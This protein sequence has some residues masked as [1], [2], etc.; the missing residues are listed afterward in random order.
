MA[1]NIDK[2]TNFCIEEIEKF[3]AEHRDETFYGFAIDAGGL[4]L[5]SVE[6]AAKT[7]KRYRDKEDRLMRHIEKW[8]DITKEDF[9]RDASYDYKVRDFEIF[10]GLNQKDKEEFLA[11]ANSDRERHRSRGNY[12]H[13]ESKV[14]KLRENTG[15]WAYQGF[16]EMTQKHGFDREAYERHYGMSDERQK[17]SAYGKAMDELLQRLKE[18]DVFKDLKKTDDFYIIRVEHNY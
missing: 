4:C 11:E 8:E 12:Y 13:D 10:R 5:N 18:S 3:I 2:L 6:E 14:K 15:D 7:L 17:T 1:F 9:Y 16:A